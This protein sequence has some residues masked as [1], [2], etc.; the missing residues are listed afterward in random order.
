M[1]DFHYCIKR[2]FCRI[3]KKLYQLIVQGEHKEKKKKIKKTIIK[4]DVIVIK[5]IKN[6]HSIITI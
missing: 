4:C 6:F 2:Y 1:C 3:K 5:S